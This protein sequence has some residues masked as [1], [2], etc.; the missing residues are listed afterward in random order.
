M[1][2]CYMTY[3][4][5]MR[6]LLAHRVCLTDDSVTLTL[7][8]PEEIDFGHFFSQRVRYLSY[9]CNFREKYTYRKLLFKSTYSKFVI[10][11]RK[12]SITTNFTSFLPKSTNSGDRHFKKRPFFVEIELKMINFRS[13]IFLKNMSFSIQ[14]C[15]F[16]A[17]TAVIAI[18]S[19]QMYG[20]A[21]YILE[22]ICSSKKAKSCFLE[23]S[24]DFKW[25]WQY[26]IQQLKN[27]YHLESKK[28]ILLFT[29]YA[30]FQ[31][32]LYNWKILYFSKFKIFENFFKYF[33]KNGA[34][35]HVVKNSF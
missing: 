4:L 13:K 9:R 10:F 17:K 29:K 18:K 12:P 35:F 22:L 1:P 11:D 3:H 24:P 32:K 5:T 19:N 23:N 8:D 2:S 14:I 21:G 31:K 33:R 16:F 15:I 28:T 7:G 25:T 26:G 34:F 30:I 6:D 20:L 27:Q